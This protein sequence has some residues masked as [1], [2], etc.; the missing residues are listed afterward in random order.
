[1]WC[2]VLTLEESRTIQME[3]LAEG[4]KEEY[5]EVRLII[6]ETREVPLVDGDSVDIYIKAFFTQDS[7]DSAEI[8]K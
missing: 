3:R 4:A 8:V 2:E 5:Y 6:W 7:F 1:M